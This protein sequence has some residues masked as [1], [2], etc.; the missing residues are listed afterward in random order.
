MGVEKFTSWVRNKIVVVAAIPTAIIEA[1]R[2]SSPV[3]K[4]RRIID[5]EPAIRARVHR[6]TCPKPE[7]S[8]ILELA[9]VEH[10]VAL[11]TLN[12][13]QLVHKQ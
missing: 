6:I 12:Y 7:V 2:V 8:I 5:I 11:Q 9:P 10:P 3:I 4:R 13:R 1:N